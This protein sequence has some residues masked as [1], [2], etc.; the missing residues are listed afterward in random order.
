[1]TKN[2]EIKKSTETTSNDLEIGD[3][4][5]FSEDIAWVTAIDFCEA[6]ENE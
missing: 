5:V 6:S 3:I 1:M 2:V 4:L